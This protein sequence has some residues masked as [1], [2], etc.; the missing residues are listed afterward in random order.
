LK[1]HTDPKS[2]QKGKGKGGTN[3]EKPKCTNPKCSKVGHMIQNCWAEGG[4][5]EGKGPKAK[6]NNAKPSDAKLAEAKAKIAHVDESP[7]EEISVLLS[8]V[9]TKRSDDEV[10]LTSKVVGKLPRD[11]WILDSGALWHVT[12]DRHIMMTYNDLSSPM[13]IW[14]ADNSYIL[15]EGVG[16]VYM[17]AIVNG[18]KTRCLF[19][20]ILYAPRMAGSLISI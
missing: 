5:A 20:D 17:D 15:A 9:G 14:L 6:T 7:I 2:K 16:H 13:R 3:G 18:Q 8:S 12:N 19:K 11:A 1:A 4:G 10:Y